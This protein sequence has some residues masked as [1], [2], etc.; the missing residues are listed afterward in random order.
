MS[1][2][3]VRRLA[4]PLLVAAV[5]VTYLWTLRDGHDWGGDF[6]GYIAHARNIVEGRPYADI[7]YLYDPEPPLHAPAA[8]PPV[9]PALLAAVYKFRGLDYHAFKVL[10]SIFLALCLVPL[11]FI[12]RDSLPPAASLVVCAFT[13]WNY[14][15]MELKEH[16]LS[17]ST[18]LFLS[19]ITIAAVNE[20]YRRSWNL[21][22]PYWSGA[23]TGILLA[24]AYGTRVV[25]VALVAAVLIYDLW[26]RRRVT[27]YQ[28]TIV[29][30]LVPAYWFVAHLMPPGG[31]YASQLSLQPAVYIENLLSY[32]RMLSYPWVNGYGNSVRLPL[33]AVFTMGAVYGVCLR[34]RRR[35][36]GV[37]DIYAVLFVL[38]LIGYTAGVNV[39]YLVPVLPVY[40]I[41]AAEGVQSAILVLAR[42]WRTAAA[43]AFAGA[44]LLT[45]AGAVTTI[46]RG[47]IENG[48]RRGDFLRT[49]EYIRRHTAPAGV[50]ITWNPRVL[51]LYSGR[52]WALYVETQDP[53]RF[54]RYIDRIH[55]TYILLYRG[56]PA[57]RQWLEP[58]LRKSPDR[59][60]PEFSDG[61]FELFRVI[62]H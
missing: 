58:I 16:V 45:C 27:A 40:F 23:A 53:H 31:G 62:G 12:A 17:D 10:T 41:Y 35:R 15:F 11:Y 2:A 34:L 30:C 50:F 57:D 49:C 4:L 52:E 14:T 33:F 21:S 28:A 19:L 54:W 25:A 36:I 5:F 61:D 37:I 42:R 59:V 9:F 8:Y 3:L 44:A 29:A 1:E 43:G 47:P 7:G 51:A 38:M 46:D 56:E 55:A 24:L 26:R 39:R 13:G 48:I 32:M 6:A 22:H 60:R 20:V 18:Y